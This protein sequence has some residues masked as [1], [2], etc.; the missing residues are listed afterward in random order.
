MKRDEVIAELE[1]EKATLNSMLVESG[2]L[3][4]GAKEGDVI[5]I[6]DIVATIDTD[7]AV[8]D[9]QATAP[10]ATAAPVAASAQKEAP[11]A[12]QPASDVKATPVA[13]AIIADKKIDP[14]NITASG[15]AGRIVKGDVL[16]ALANPGKQAFNGQELLSEE[17]AQGK[18]DEPAQNHQQ[19]PG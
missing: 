6:G 10:K 3:S 13:A 4:L 12:A 7:I 17:C 2:K 14:K 8:P 5:K 16:A 18:N 1:S 11:A 19:A 9:Q 15:S